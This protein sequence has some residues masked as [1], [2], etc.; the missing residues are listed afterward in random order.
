MAAP[1]KASI[2]AALSAY[3]DNERVKERDRVL[4]YFSGHGQTVKLATGGETGFH[5]DTEGVGGAAGAGGCAP[6]RGGN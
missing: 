3:T 2:E 5:A 6:G 4:V 1:T